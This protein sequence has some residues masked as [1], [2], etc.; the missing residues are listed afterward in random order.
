MAVG[1]ATI[2]MIN[3]C[4]TPEERARE[5]NAKEN[6][7]VNNATGEQ[8]S[9]NEN[10]VMPDNTSSYNHSEAAESTPA[11]TADRNNAVLLKKKAVH[12][13][14]IID[15]HDAA[16]SNAKVEVMPSFPGGETSLNKFVED[17]LQYPEEALENNVEGR[18]LI[19]FDVDETGKIYRPNV[20]SNKL[21]YGLEE[22]ALKVI[23]SMPQWNPGRL[24]GKNVKTTFT[25]PIVYQLI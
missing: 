11:T 15:M 3:A 25:L 24:Q 13:R 6:S 20:V 21:G 1:L 9:A 5:M 10:A 19:T 2:F 4:Q 7:T 23:K 16:K 8:A 17:N 22:E 12:G 18:V 14:A